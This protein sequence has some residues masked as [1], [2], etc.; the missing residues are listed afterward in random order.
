MKPAWLVRQTVIWKLF[1][2]KRKEVRPRS[3]VSRS[4]RRPRR[5]HPLKNLLDR[6]KNSLPNLAK[7]AKPRRPPTKRRP[8]RGAVERHKRYLLQTNVICSLRNFLCTKK[9]RLFVISV[10]DS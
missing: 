8:R 10:S 1:Q 9:K 5:Q 7:P 3:V 6:R 4:K 2:R